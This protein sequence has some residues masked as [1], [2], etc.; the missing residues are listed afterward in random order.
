MTEPEIIQALVAAGLLPSEARPSTTEELAILDAARDCLSLELTLDG[1]ARAGR[2]GQALAEQE[3]AVT[4]QMTTAGLPTEDVLARQARVRQ[5]I[6]RLVSAV[7]HAAVSRAMTR[8]LE[9][10]EAFSGYSGEMLHTPSNLYI[11]QHGL[12]LEVA[13]ARAAAGSDGPEAAQY[14]GRLLI[15]IGRYAEASPWLE[16]AAA[17]C[18]PGGRVLDQSR[19]LDQSHALDH[20]RAV[21]LAHNAIGRLFLGGEASE[22][23]DE[24]L[25]A[26]P[27]SMVAL[28]FSAVIRA[29]EAGRTESV[30]QAAAAVRDALDFLERSRTGATPL[31]GLAKLEALLAR[32]RLSVL[33]PLDFGLRQLGVADLEEVLSSPELANVSPGVAGIFRLHAAWF[34]GMTLNG[35]DAIRACQTVVVTDPASP[36]A[37]RAYE[38]IGELMDNG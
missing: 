29:W 19:A 38:R 26:C 21:A 5:H 10:G 36:T 4:V 33:L 28:A 2:V 11:A 30:S 34:L 17:G 31:D 23:A 7:R 27:T 1:V 6:T 32:G 3:L 14:L 37:E 35:D 15:G 9:L 18:P 16:I 20:S 13:E 12:E 24:A 8:L 22:L 25:A